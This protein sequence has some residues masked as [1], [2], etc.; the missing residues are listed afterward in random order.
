MDVARLLGQAKEQDGPEKYSYSKMHTFLQCPQKAYQ[1]YILGKKE[2]KSA[3]MVLG[4]CVH[5]VHEE[6]NIQKV[7]KG[8]GLP[9]ESLIELLREEFREQKVGK[10]DPL[11]EQHREQLKVYAPDRDKLMPVTGSIEGQWEVQVQLPEQEPA[12]V[13]GFVD[14]MAYE[15][16]GEKVTWDYKNVKRAFTDKEAEKSVQLELYRIGSGT[17]LAGLIQFVGGA[18]QRPTTRITKVRGTPESR[19]KTLRVVAS[20]I[21]GWRAAVRTGVWPK[22]APEQYYCAPG[23]CGFYGT[24]YPRESKTPAI[25]VGKVS[26]V[27]S[28]PPA[29]W[30]KDKKDVVPGVGSTAAEGAQEGSGDHFGAVGEGRDERVSSG[31]GGGVGSGGAGSDGSD[32]EGPGRDGESTGVGGHQG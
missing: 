18:R 8:V 15:D 13:W 28:L 32:E 16:S 22:C 9:D 24:C 30:R 23:V 7:E 3:A 10:P 6:D 4:D 12:V 29:D 25:A 26:L 1:R 17:E 11:L 27:G 5:K 2:P 14:L 20:A 31:G 19:E 21:E